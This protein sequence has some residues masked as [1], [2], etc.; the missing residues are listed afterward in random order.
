M[1]QLH[2]WY[3]CY[4]NIFIIIKINLEHASI[5]E[6]IDVEPAIIEALPDSIDMQLAAF[7]LNWQMHSVSSKGTL[8]IPPC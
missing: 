5:S 3:K 6:P 2:L 4:S 1:F 7:E 8:V